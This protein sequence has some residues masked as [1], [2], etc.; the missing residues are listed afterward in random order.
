MKGG[1]AVAA[2]VAEPDADVWGEL[3]REEWAAFV[4][5]MEQEQRRE[6][7]PRPLPHRN[8]RHGRR[9]PRRKGARP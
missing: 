2:G 3:G 6:G 9:H 8:T 1:A 7:R 5:E 4:A